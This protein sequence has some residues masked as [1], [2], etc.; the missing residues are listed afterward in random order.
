MTRFSLRLAA[1]PLLALAACGAGDGAPTG[2]DPPGEYATQ[3]EVPSPDYAALI[4][5]APAIEQAEAFREP[6]AS[7]PANARQLGALW[8]ARLEERGALMGHGLAG[9]EPD[10][11]VQSIDTLLTAEEFDAW[12]AENGWTV[13]PHLHWYF[14]QPLIAP[15]VS[16]TAQG[17]I[18]TWPASEAR[19]GW[20]LEAAFVGRIYLRDGCFFM[21]SDVVD[22]PDKLAWF[23]AETGLDV[24]AEGYYT[25]VNRVNS[26]P[27]ARLGEVM[28]WA[29]PNRLDQ[30]A[31]QIIALRQV[32][33]DYTV[34]GVG[35]PEANERMFVTYPHLRQPPDAI[36]PPGIE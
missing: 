3:L 14:Q 15:R 29:G 36:P 20:Q 8:L 12:V 32:C 21:R 7:P 4:A 31:P 16:E 1:L 11:P 25:L 17:G 5:N 28:T 22:A 33:G 18:R 26:Q 27:V 35:N 23:H 13:P 6:T 34:E 2:S 24:D 30:D 10:A 19:T 9:K